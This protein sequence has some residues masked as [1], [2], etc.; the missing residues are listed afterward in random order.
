MNA[1][2]LRLEWRSA[3]RRGKRYLVVTCPRTR[4]QISHERPGAAGVDSHFVSKGV[5]DV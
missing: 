1:N 5:I 2:P 3:T 4:R